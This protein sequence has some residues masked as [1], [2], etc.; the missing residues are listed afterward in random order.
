MAFDNKYDLQIRSNWYKEEHQFEGNGLFTS[1]VEGC[2][3][4]TGDNFL[5]YPL[6]AQFYLWVGPGKNLENVDIEPVRGTSDIFNYEN[7]PNIFFK[8]TNR[9]LDRYLEF[10]KTL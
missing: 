7:D 8:Y 5:I 1:Y 9:L 4:Q 6:N 10:L 3:D 2:F